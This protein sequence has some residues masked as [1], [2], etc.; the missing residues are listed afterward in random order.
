MLKSRAFCS[1][2]LSLMVF[3]CQAQIFNIEHTTDSTAVIVLT[4]D[5]S[6]NEWQI[7]YP[8]Y[9]FQ[10][11]D[12]DGDGIAEAFVGVTKSTRFDSV[13]RKRLFIFKNFRNLIRPM[14]M[15]SSLG[16]EM[17]DFVYADGRI[18]AAVKNI[19]NKCAVGEYVWD[20]FG[21]SLQRWIERDISEEKARELLIIN[22][23]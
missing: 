19:K 1:I 11:G 9:Q 21:L 18:R 8:V 3:T 16:H 22:S 14:W 23:E 12:I 15:G 2:A 20:K 13:S 5:S 17:I 6:R 7:D 4:T 10:Q